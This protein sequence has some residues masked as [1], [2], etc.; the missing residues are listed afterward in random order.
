MDNGVSQLVF[1]ATIAYFRK[2]PTLVT[3]RAFLSLCKSINTVYE[4]YT[5]YRNPCGQGFFGIFSALSI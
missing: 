3:L 5:K 2:D 1:S 4:K